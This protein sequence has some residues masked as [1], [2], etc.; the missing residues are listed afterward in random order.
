MPTSHTAAWFGRRRGS[1]SSANYCRRSPVKLKPA[2][3]LLN[4]P[5]S[6]SHSHVITTDSRIRRTQIVVTKI[7]PPFPPRNLSSREGRS[8]TC[9]LPISSPSTT[10]LPDP[11]SMHVLFTDNLTEA[12]TQSSL[13]PSELQPQPHESIARRRRKARLRRKRVRASRGDGL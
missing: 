1:A 7:T 8:P 9:R 13:S 4:R 11:I 12:S 3:G 6:T 2:R 10:P 5:H